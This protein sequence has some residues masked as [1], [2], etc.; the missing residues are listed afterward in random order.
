MEKTPPATARHHI[1]HEKAYSNAETTTASSAAGRVR[2]ANKSKLVPSDTV[3]TVIYYMVML[4][5]RK[6]GYRHSGWW[7]EA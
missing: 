1:A 3:P 4:L 5:R 6:N 2:M 7:C